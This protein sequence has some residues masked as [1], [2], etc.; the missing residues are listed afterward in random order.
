MRINGYGGRLTE[1]LSTRPRAT[2]GAGGAGS[3]G[4]PICADSS[5]V[6]Q[7]GSSG[8]VATTSVCL[9][10][11]ASP[12]ASRRQTMG[13]LSFE[14]RRGTLGWG[15]RTGSHIASELQGNDRPREGHG[16]GVSFRTL[17]F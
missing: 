8:T 10:T 13:P 11:G 16:G 7:F 9:V 12:E 5:S 3:P 2:L 15:D 1:R 6:T 17:G 4:S 14:L